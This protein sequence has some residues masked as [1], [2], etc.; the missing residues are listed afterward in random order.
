[1]IKIWLLLPKSWHLSDRWPNNENMQIT[2][3]Y[4]MNGS[5]PG[6][7][8]NSPFPFELFL[9]QLISEAKGKV[10][11]ESENLSWLDFRIPLALSSWDILHGSGLGFRKAHFR[12]FTTD[13]GGGKEFLAAFLNL[14]IYI[15]KGSYVFS[16]EGWE[17][18]GPQR[19]GSSVKVSTKRGGSYLFVGYSKGRVTH[20]S[21]N[22]LTRIFV[23]LLSIFL[24]DLV[25]L[26]IYFDL[27]LCF[28]IG[29]WLHFYMYIMPWHIVF[30]EELCPFPS[31][32]RRTR[33]R[34]R[35]FSFLLLLTIHCLISWII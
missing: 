11:I 14:L 2:I 9:Y 29:S 5:C 30:S 26:F 27:I 8:E 12:F 18:S 24:T 23:M 33:L 10:I 7:A 28:T 15:N 32:S 4:P 16:W 17:G 34:Y 22:F 35:S 6:A 21:H 13:E 3:Q 20:L 1:M 31:V 19:G 25:F